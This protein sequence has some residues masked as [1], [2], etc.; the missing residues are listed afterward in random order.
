MG[1]IQI[2]FSAI[3]ILSSYRIAEDLKKFSTYSIYNED[4]VAQIEYLKN[5]NSI[6][7]I[8][9]NA[10]ESWLYL[11]A[12]KISSSKYFSNLGPANNFLYSRDEYIDSIEGDR[13]SI[14]V[15]HLCNQDLNPN[16]ICHEPLNA[17]LEESYKKDLVIDNLEFWKLR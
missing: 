8:A 1:R 2:L 9:V 7:R 11:Q 13:T 3:I 4:R 5:Y 14:I 6:D 17:V 12:S 15:T 16:F 10:S